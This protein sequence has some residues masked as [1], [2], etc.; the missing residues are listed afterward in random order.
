MKASETITELATALSN[1]QNEVTDAHKGAQGHNYKYADLGTILQLVRP[2]MYAHGLSVIQM[3]CGDALNMGLSTRLMHNSGE[4][5]ED[6][7]YMGV[8]ASRGMS[9]AQAAG[10]VI[11]Y[12]RRYALAAVLGITQTDDDA[13]VKEIEVFPATEEQK[14]QIT[15][16]MDDNKMSPRRAVWCQKNMKTMTAKAAETVISELEEAA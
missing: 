13:A 7:Q 3:P 10:S 12:M 5:I 6:T 15:K 9:E 11:T 16:A 4:W 1:F 8:S 14:A 2:L